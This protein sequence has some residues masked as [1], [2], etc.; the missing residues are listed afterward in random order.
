[1]SKRFYFSVDVTELL[2]LLFRHEVRYL[3]VGGEAVIYY[4]HARLTGDIDIFYE[5]K[6]ENAIN[7]FTALEEFW[8]NSVPGIRKSEE[9][10]IKGTVFQFGV[11]PNRIDLM[12]VIEKV[13]F[14][15]AWEHRNDTSAV[16]KGKK[17]MIHYIGLHELI[18][19][20]EAVGRYRD[21]DDLLFLN[22]QVSKIGKKV[23]NKS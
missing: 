2:S 14:K 20:K 1:M 3:I 5:R 13:E 11:P 23:R 7:L 16:I 8:G 6:P 9:L 4:G 17:I 19:N 21:K 22:A 12:N 15:D 10:L 18:K